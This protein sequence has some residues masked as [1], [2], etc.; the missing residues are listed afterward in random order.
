MSSYAQTT[1]QFGTRVLEAVK[2]AADVVARAVETLSRQ[3]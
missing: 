3:G 2:P 1:E